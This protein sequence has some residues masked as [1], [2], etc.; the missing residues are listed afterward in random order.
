MPRFGTNLSRLYFYLSDDLDDDILMALTEFNKNLEQISIIEC[1]K[2]TD[3]GIQAVTDGQ[4]KLKKLVLRLMPNLTSQ[5]LINVKAD[6]LISVDLSCCSKIT[7]DGI[8]HLVFANPT[9]RCLYLNHCRGLGDQ[10]LYDVAHCLGEN[11]NV[12]EV[13]YLRNLEDPINTI[14]NLSQHC[15]NIRQLSLIKMFNF[16]KEDAEVPSALRISGVNLKD[17]DLCGNYFFQLPLLPQT[18]HTIRLSV[19]GDEDVNDLIN[20]L[21]EQP[22]LASIHLHISCLEDNNCKTSQV[23][24]K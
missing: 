4:R 5:A 21:G 18:I 2:V 23:T 22:H 17:V 13:D 20:R 9:I 12:L 16:E 8:F 11:L 19:C 14:C 3:R 24:Q 15:P 1:P 7:S 10:A 6:H